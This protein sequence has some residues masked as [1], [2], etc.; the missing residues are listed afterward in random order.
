MCCFA[1]RSIKASLLDF[2]LCIW[3][4]CL[5]YA[6]INIKQKQ[7]LR[8]RQAKPVV[9]CICTNNPEDTKHAFQPL[10][11]ECGVGCM[12]THSCSTCDFL[13]DFPIVRERRDCPCVRGRARAHTLSHKRGSPIT[14]RE[15]IDLVLSV[16]CARRILSLYRIFALCT[17]V[18]R[19]CLCVCLCVASQRHHPPV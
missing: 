10:V 11:H 6:T 18:L 4:S 14:R 7:L 3:I 12:P 9:V 13:M 19:V 15:C 16:S 2:M 17:G 1:S 5:K 8:E